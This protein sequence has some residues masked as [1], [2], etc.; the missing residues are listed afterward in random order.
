MFRIYIFMNNTNILMLQSVQSAGPSSLKMPVKSAA[1]FVAM[2]K[3]VN[4][5]AIGER[6][7][8]RANTSTTF[9]NRKPRAQRAADFRVL[10]SIPLS[11]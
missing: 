11:I 4:E 5:K 3:Q 2:R 9:D 1:C 8:E 7:M 10:R 6:V